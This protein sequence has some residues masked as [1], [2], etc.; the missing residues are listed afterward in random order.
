M[1]KFVFFILSLFIFNACSTPEE[2]ALKSLEKFTAKM[3]QQSSSWSEEE[4]SQAELQFDKI[5]HSLERYKYS[6]EDLRYIG[7]LEGRCAGLFVKHCAQQTRDVIHDTARELEGVMS[8]LQDIFG[9]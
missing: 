7:R 8:G 6:D 9:E 5:Q 4:W 2:S 3:E 1:K